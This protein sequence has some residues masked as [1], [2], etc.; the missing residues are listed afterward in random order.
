[1]KNKKITVDSVLVA[2]S[3]VAIVLVAFYGI[4]KDIKGND[5]VAS[6]VSA[7]SSETDWYYLNEHKIAEFQTVIIETFNDE[8]KLIVKSI[9]ASVSVT[10]SN[11]AFM[12]WSALKKTQTLTYTGTGN[13]VIDLSLL[14]SQNIELDNENSKVVIS[15]PRPQLE[16]VEIDPDLFEAT[17][18]TSG[19]LAF[20]EMTFTAQEYNDLEKK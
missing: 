4:R 11:D 2:L 8:S 3:V 9:E 18:T 17:E 6:T 10:L 7:E 19:I 5:V 1:M 12:N 15:V 20:G 14:G 16:P 13:F